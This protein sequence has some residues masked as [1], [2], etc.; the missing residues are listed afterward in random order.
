M[1]LLHGTAEGMRCLGALGAVRPLSMGRM[2]KCV[3]ESLGQPGL[4]P[5]DLTITSRSFRLLFIAMR[6]T[7]LHSAVLILLAGVLGGHFTE[8]FDHWD[9]TLQT[10]RESDY[11]VV[12]IAACLGVA[13]AIGKMLVSASR[14]LFSGAKL[15]QISLPAFPGFRVSPE[16]IDTGPPLLSLSPL[17]I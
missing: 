10:G 17:R 2:Q 4:W 15:L 5:A 1:R 7:L 3:P 8:L 13:F 14:R 16:P 9:H 11:S 6:K 12:V